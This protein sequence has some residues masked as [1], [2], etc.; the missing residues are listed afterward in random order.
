MLRDQPANSADAPVVN[1]TWD[2]AV[3]YC[4]WLSKKSG[5]IYRLP[6]EA[7]WEW[8]ARAGEQTRW[9]GSD[10]D[11][12]AAAIHG[13]VLGKKSKPR[14]ANMGPAP[15]PFGLVNMLGNVREWVQDSWQPGYAGAPVDGQPSTVGYESGARWKLPLNRED[16]RLGARQKLE[17]SSFDDETGFGWS[18]S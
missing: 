8:A 11:I 15:K 2:E 17:S 3:R 18:G 16:L 13:S 6:S 9:P 7:E 14:S 1:V 12:N 10:K 5:A 4:D